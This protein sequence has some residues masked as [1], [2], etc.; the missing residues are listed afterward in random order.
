MRSFVNPALCDDGV[1]KTVCSVRQRS[2]AGRWSL[3]QRTPI[4]PLLLITPEGDNFLRL[5]HNFSLFCLFGVAYPHSGRWNM[6]S[7]GRFYWSA[8]R[9]SSFSLG[10]RAGR[11]RMAGN[12]AGHYGQGPTSMGLRSNLHRSVPSFILLTEYPGV[13]K[14]PA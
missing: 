12:S 10:P 7:S 6:M 3:S 11:V 4:R 5:E 2:S 9:H 14:E 1:R 8:I 13:F